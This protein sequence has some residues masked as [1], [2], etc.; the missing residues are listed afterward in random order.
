MGAVERS[1]LRVKSLVYEITVKRKKDDLS[2]SRS[3][4]C[5]VTR[6]KTLA[7][8]HSLRDQSLSYELSSYPFVSHVI[9]VDARPES[10]SNRAYA[11]VRGDTMD[12]REDER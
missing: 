1:G 11:R 9:S 10:E 5:H 7:Q 6:V 8:P 4:F 3:F 2:D 12:D